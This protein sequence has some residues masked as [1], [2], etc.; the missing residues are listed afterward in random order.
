[1]L[2]GPKRVKFKKTKKGT[3]GKFEYKANNLNFGTIGLKAVESGIISSR[4]IEAARQAIARKIKRKGKI[5][6]RIF[7]Y[8]PITA[9]STGVRMGKGKGKISHWGARV[10]GGEV[11][12]EIC[13]INFNTVFGALKT[14][15]AKLPIKTKIFT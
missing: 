4:Q 9:K 5:W 12:F 10:R 3:L 6:I 14:G 1:M 7:P 2:N 13:G 11:L 15:G 8:L